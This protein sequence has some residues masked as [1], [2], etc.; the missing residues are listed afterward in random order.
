M[1]ALLVVAGVAHAGAVG[2]FEREALAAVRTLRGPSCAPVAGEFAI[3]CDDGTF[4]L[5]NAYADWRAVR[6][7]ARDAVLVHYFQPLPDLPADWASAAEHVR[8]RV[9][10]RLYELVTREASPEADGPQLLCRPL[11]GHLCVEL[12][13]DLPTAIMS[14]S[15]ARLAEW[16]VSEDEAYAAGAQ[17]LAASAADPFEHVGEGVWTSHV[18]DNYDSSRLLLPAI[19]DLAVDGEPVAVPAT[20]DLLVIA[21][22]DDLD[23]L[24]VLLATATR[25]LDDPRVD[26]ARPI[27]LQDGAWRPFT[28]PAGHP[29]RGALDNLVH[30]DLARDY[31]AQKALLDRENTRADRDVFVATY[32]LFEGERGALRSASSWAPIATC[33]PHTDDYGVISPDGTEVAI[34]PAERVLAQEGTWIETD[35]SLVPARWCSTGVLTEGAYDELTSG[36]ERQ[37]LGK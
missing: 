33:N 6:R 18:G 10:N 35:P 16:G 13:Y 31:D 25:A 23:A 11:A 9:R 36:I 1:S 22:S 29:L 26:S 24:K 20:R 32:L 14:V 30:R 27:V 7:G 2:R 5:N 12:V 8:L 3:R 4:H 34:V 28:V 21:G 17:R 37:P 15:P 19:A